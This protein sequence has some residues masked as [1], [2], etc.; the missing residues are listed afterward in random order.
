L[1]AI[2]RCF[3]G[4][5]AAKPRFEPPLELL[6]LLVVG[7]FPLRL[8][9]EEARTK[10]IS[11]IPVHCPDPGCPLAQARLNALLGHCGYSRFNH[12]A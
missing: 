5:I 9:G 1:L 8:S 6:L 4:L 2:S 3:S 11:S 7:M 10:R 12:P